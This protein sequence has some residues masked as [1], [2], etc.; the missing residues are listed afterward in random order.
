MKAFLL[1]GGHGERLRP[2]TDHL[3]KCLVPIGGVPLL[4]IWI[5]LCKRSGVEEVLVN[6]SRNVAAVERVLDA[7]TPAIAV[8]VVEER[9]PVGNAGTVLRHRD[10]VRGEDNFLV[11]YADNLTDADLGSLVRFHQSHTEPLTMGLF[12]T[13]DPAGAGIV[14]LGEEGKVGAF[15]EKPAHPVSDLANAGIYVCR[16]SLFDAIPR[17]PGIVDFAID[18][19]PVLGEQLRG[20]RLAG[21]VQD[22]GTPEGLARAQRDWPRRIAAAVPPS[23]FE[24]RR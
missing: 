5:D 24:V 21:Y 11:L 23:A 15:H 6:V 9:Q 14:E 20:Q 18:V 12:R 8:R 2:F 22:V 4:R 16:P 10:F 1:A 17:H 19:F 13:A 3:P 7:D